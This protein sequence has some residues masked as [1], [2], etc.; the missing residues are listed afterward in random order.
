MA[1]PALVVAALVLLVFTILA[2]RRSLRLSRL[3]KTLKTLRPTSVAEATEN[4]LQLV[5]GRIAT[6]DPIPSAFRGRRCAYYAFRV[7]DHRLDKPKPR[8][9]AVGKDWATIEIE[10]ETGTATIDARPALIRAPH[11]HVERL[12]R[13]DDVPADKA[14]F[15][16]QAGIYERHLARFQNLH[17]IEYTLEPGDELFVLGTVRSENGRKVFYRAKHSPLAVSETS[18]AG[19]VPGYRNELLLFSVAAVLLATFAAVFFVVSF[20]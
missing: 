15:F 16:E 6:P 18:D 8:R 3:I 1:E 19:L 17:V 5:R 4:E 10:D 9:L 20:A 7:E 12:G 2:A 13:I 14:E 11:E